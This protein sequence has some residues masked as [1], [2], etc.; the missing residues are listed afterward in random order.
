VINDL[1]CDKD[2]K[3]SDATMQKKRKREDSSDDAHLKFDP[4]NSVK[5]TEHFRW[6]GIS[7]HKTRLVI[8]AQNQSRKKGRMLLNFNLGNVSEFREVEVQFI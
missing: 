6:T 8:S 5:I 7:H 1:S 3:T 2:E 4:E